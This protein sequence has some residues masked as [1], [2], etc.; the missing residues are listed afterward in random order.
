[1]KRIARVSPSVLM[2]TV[3]S[4][5]VSGE[6]NSPGSEEQFGKAAI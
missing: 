1:M 6:M 2:L 3:Y 4:Q 5:V